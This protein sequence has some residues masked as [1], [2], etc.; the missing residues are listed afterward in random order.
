VLITLGVT[1]LIVGFNHAECD[2]YEL[3]MVL[4]R[5]LELKK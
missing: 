5:H 1:Q 4:E 3:E 2:D